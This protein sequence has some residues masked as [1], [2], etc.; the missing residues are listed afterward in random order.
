M[1]SRCRLSDAREAALRHL[2]ADESVPG[3]R[4][5]LLY[6]GKLFNLLVDA[7]EEHAML[8]VKGVARPRV[9]ECGGQAPR[10]VQGLS[11]TRVHAIRRISRTCE[12]SLL[13][14]AKI[15]I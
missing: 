2:A 11:C 1:A 10:G 7:K 15:W 14:I 3:F 5:A 13:E 6:G 9:E 4:T 8:P 12:R